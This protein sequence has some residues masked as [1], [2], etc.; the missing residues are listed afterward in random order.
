MNPLLQLLFGQQGAPGMAQPEIPE[1]V[2]SGI[3]V[4]G[5]GPSA[6]EPAQERDFLLGNRQFLQ[7]AD[8]A[9]QVRDD[10]RKE[11]PRKGM[12]GVKGTLRDILGVVGD[13]FLVQSG[14]KAIYGPRRDQERQA[15]AMAGFTH[16]P[17]QA[18][19]AIEQLSALDPAAGMELQKQIEQ[20]QLRQVQQQGLQDARNSQIEAR[21]T[22]AYEKG[23][24]AIARIANN[25]NAYGPDG[26]LTPEARSIMER[27]ATGTG[28]T[29][30]DFGIDDTFDRNRGS[31]F[32]SSGATV[33]QQNTLPIQQQRADAATS[34]AGSSRIRA[35]R[36]P[37]GRNPPQ[38]TP[39]TMLRDFLAIPENQRTQEQKDFIKR[40]TQPTGKSG[41]TLR[42]DPLSTGSR[43]GLQIRPVGQ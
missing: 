41:R 25:P 14:N 40:Q 10:Y 26:R 4:S 32:A 2:G 27:M 24:E 37:A 21:G 20:Q 22:A 43:P 34:Q 39:T 3:T 18:N 17:E 35:N 1:T 6:T 8:R 42:S 5:Q 23:R 38:P 15:D 13:G 33:N 36:P 16:S 30:E 11:N 12:F 7:E 28:K 9:Q 29:L 31:L 19:I